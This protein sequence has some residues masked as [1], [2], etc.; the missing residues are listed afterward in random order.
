MEF[1]APSR[2]SS[3]PR[4]RRCGTDRIGRW[5]SR[6]P[7]AELGSLPKD[8]LQLRP[9]QQGI[10]LGNL[11]VFNR[12]QPI[13]YIDPLGLSTWCGTCEEYGFGI[14][15]L[16]GKFVHCYLTTSCNDTKGTYEYISVRAWFAAAGLGIPIPVN[17]SKSKECFELPDGMDYTAFNGSA[18][19]VDYEATVG[20]GISAG[21]MVFGYAESSGWSNTQGFDVGIGF[22][23]GKASVINHTESNCCK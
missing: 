3:Q 5:L 1:A 8:A 11:M 16:E 10:E 17:Y 2:L 4:L 7:V 20:G 18:R 23:S 15:V 22:G 12:N 13:T 6:D 14:K 9:R 19:F 21:K